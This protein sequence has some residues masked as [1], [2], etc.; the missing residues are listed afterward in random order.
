MRRLLKIF[1]RASE[2]PKKDGIAFSRVDYYNNLEDNPKLTEYN[3]YSIGMQSN[4]E[5][6]Q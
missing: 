3:L 6:Y 2:T 1:K 5:Q 4:Q